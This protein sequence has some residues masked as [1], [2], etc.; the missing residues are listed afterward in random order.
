MSSSGDLYTVPPGEVDYELVKAFVRSAEGTNLFAESL[1]FEVKEKL[2]KGNIADAVAALSN[3]DGGVVLVGVKDK[4]TTGEDRIVGVPKS[5]HDA[6]ASNLH[7]LIPEAM[8]EIIPVA[9]P[10]G[11]R[12]V[13]VLRVDADAVPHPVTVSGKVLFRDSWPLGTRRPAPDP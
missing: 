5:E 6:V 12:L 11:D 3:S 8:P 9:I 13:L 1:T 7:A 2:N 4:D 10:G